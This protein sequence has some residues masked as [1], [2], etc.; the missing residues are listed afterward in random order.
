VE[1]CPFKDVEFF[2][3]LW[4]CALSKMSSFSASC[5]AVPLQRCRVFPQAVELCPFSKRPIITV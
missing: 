3:K 4:S 2:R 5:G 1:L